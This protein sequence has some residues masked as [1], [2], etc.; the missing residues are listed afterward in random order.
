[1]TES[2]MSK[3]SHNNL[4]FINPVNLLQQSKKNC[5][6]A[7]WDPVSSSSLILPAAGADLFTPLVKV[8]VLRSINT[9]TPL[10]IVQVLR[11]QSSKPATF[12]QVAQSLP[13]RES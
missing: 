4:V 13:C 9:L 7:R 6:T 3:L 11:S 2:K 5:F 1:M 10:S 8:Q 12:V